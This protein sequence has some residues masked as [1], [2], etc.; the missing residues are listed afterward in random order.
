MYE[1]SF[2]IELAQY[3]YNDILYTLVFEIEVNCIESC[4]LHFIS[5]YVYI[6]ISLILFLRDSPSMDCALAGG[7]R[8]HGTD[9]SL[10]M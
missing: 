5:I 8:A 3:M 9:G 4:L 10:T 1:F 2:Q 7:I 6:Y